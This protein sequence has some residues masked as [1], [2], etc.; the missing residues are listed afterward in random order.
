MLLFDSIFKHKK[1]ALSG[2]SL[3]SGIFL[4]F[5]SLLL[6]VF[7]FCFIDT[8]LSFGSCEFLLIIAVGVAAALRGGLDKDPAQVLAA[9]LVPHADAGLGADALYRAVAVTPVLALARVVAFLDTE[10]VDLYVRGTAVVT[11]A[12]GW[13][14]ARAHHGERPSSAIGLVLGAVVVLALVGVLAS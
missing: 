2:A 8:L 11:R 6:I 13:A 7:G 3:K 4:G 1:N 5:F 9:R 10:V 12:A 14:G